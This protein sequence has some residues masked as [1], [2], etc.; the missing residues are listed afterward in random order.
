MSQELA[1]Q[2]GAIFFLAVMMIAGTKMKGV[3]PQFGRGVQYVLI[4]MGVLGACFLALRT[5]PE[6]YAAIASMMTN[7]P[8]AAAH[9]ALV[10]G[11]ATA[12]H[13][14][15]STRSAI[16]KPAPHNP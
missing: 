15:V 4:A 5:W 2:I 9:P 13:A 14:A 12:S 3:F 1:F 6:A 8:Q 10:D 7:A 16:P 11:P